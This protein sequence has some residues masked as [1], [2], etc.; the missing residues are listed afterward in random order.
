MILDNC[1]SAWSPCQPDVCL[2]ATEGQAGHYL[3]KSYIGFSYSDPVDTGNDLLYVSQNTF[4]AIFPTPLI[5]VLLKK[6]NVGTMLTSH[7]AAPH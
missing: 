6:V 3:K 1:L 2:A 4:V 5:T 7:P